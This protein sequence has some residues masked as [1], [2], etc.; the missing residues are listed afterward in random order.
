MNNTAEFLNDENTFHGIIPMTMG[1]RLEMLVIGTDKETIM[2]LW[3]WLCMEAMHMESI[4][5]RF[6]AGSELTGL[7]CATGPVKVSS[8][9]AEMIR[10]SLRF[11]ERTMGLFDISKGYYKEIEISPDDMAF[12]HGHPLDFGGIAKGCLLSRLRER[13]ITSGVECAF[14]DF[15]SSS[16]LTMGHHP[17]GDCWKVGVQN[18]FGYGSLAEIE[19]KGESMSTSGNTPKHGLHII[20]PRTGRPNNEKKA[21]TVISEDPLEA[22]VVS[23]A[24]MLADE[25][26]KA[27]ILTHFP[28]MKEQ[29]FII[30]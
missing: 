23:T 8:T 9:L 4:L 24:L 20:D 14:V 11:S 22:E 17:Y 26:Q 6:N 1:T 2:P 10:L 18:P 25:E 21:V 29:T 15:G 12:T 28:K 5:N 19:L 30:A 7:N 3:N 27:E 16:I 13:F